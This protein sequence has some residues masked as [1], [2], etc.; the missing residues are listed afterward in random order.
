M[1]NSDTCQYPHLLHKGLG[2]NGINSYWREAG[3]SA[4]SK[5]SQWFSILIAGYSMTDGEGKLC[6]FLEFDRMSVQNIFTISFHTTD[7]IPVPHTTTG[8]TSRWKHPPM[9]VDQPLP[10]LL[11]NIGLKGSLMVLC[12]IRFFVCIFCFS[13]SNVTF[14]FCKMKIEWGKLLPTAGYCGDWNI[15]F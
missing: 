5:D 4:L 6:S 2:L 13:I 3:L 15:G 1:N 11:N 14:W 8:V 10:L 7:S 12:I 9:S